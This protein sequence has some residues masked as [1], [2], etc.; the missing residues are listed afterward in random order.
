[1]AG[2][3]EIDGRV[4][5]EE[6][7]AVSTGLTGNE[8]GRKARRGKMKRKS[9]SDDS[10]STDWGGRSGNERQKSR[11]RRTGGHWGKGTEEWNQG[12]QGVKQ[13]G[14]RDLE[15]NGRLKDRK[16]SMSGCS[17]RKRR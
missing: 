15:K 5:P 10:M 14:E 17:L 3:G 13:P 12:K 8:G 9:K 4:H 11:Q 7:L 6:L 1:M 2:A 16:Q